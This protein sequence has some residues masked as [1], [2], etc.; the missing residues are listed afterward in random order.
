[1]MVF[2][3]NSYSMTYTPW[4]VEVK[5]RLLDRHMRQDDLVKKLND[6][7]FNINKSHFTNLLK[8]IGA[9]SRKAEIEAVS[10]MLEIPIRK[11]AD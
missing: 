4:G 6:K 11:E 9:S 2:D 7:G 10:E 1:M 8:G 3:A 5:K